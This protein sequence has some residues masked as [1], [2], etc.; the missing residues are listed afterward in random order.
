MRSASGLYRYAKRTGN[1]ELFGYALKTKELAL[2]FPQT[3]GFFPGLIAA[4]MNDVEINGK[5]YN[6]SKGWDTYYF[7]N[8]NRNPYTWN[9]SIAPY[10]ILD[11]SF[12]A[13]QMLSWYIDLE[14]D[15]RLLGYCL[16]YADALL[17]KQTDDGFFPGW[18]DKETLE[19]KQHLNKSPESA[20]SATFL[21]N[22]YKITKNEK[23]MFP[24]LKCMDG[25]IDSI[26]RQ[27]RWEDFET[28]WSCSR[29]GT[30]ELVGKKVERNNQYK[31]NTLSIFWT[32][33]SL[34]ECYELT[35]E[36]KYLKYGERT[37][38]ELLMYQASWQ[39]LYIYI[40]AIGGFGVMNSDGEWND[41]RQSLFA[42][43]ILK[44]GKLL[45][46]SEYIER[47][48]AALYASFEMMYCPENP[49]TKEQWEKVW[50]FF[51][52]GD[53]G[54]MM[55]NYG[56]GGVTSKDGIGIGEFT[57]YDWGNGAAAEAYNRIVDHFGKEILR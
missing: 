30:E 18:L 2:A 47:G 54:F 55:E 45:N 43:L 38:D 31:Q 32:A 56:H 21:F 24:A 42:E 46:R 25:I 34:L 39:P 5:K 41:S 33:E 16:T 12:T 23:Y 37:L 6:R 7:G 53:Y 27:G 3:E 49:E 29:Y 13:T 36:E 19:P 20:V 28:Y 17:E 48:I 1:K 4:E 14:N 11:M 8:S 50:P 40:R 52:P 26:I 22:L 57:I 35:G 44:Y 9:A 51:G 10:H 15:Q